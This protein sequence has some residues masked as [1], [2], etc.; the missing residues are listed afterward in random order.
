MRTDAQ[1][2]GLYL[3]STLPIRRY[4]WFIEPNGARDE[5]VQKVSNDYNLPIRG[6]E[7]QPRR[8]QKHRFAF[9]NHL[10]HALLAL[11]Y[12]HMYFEQVGEIADDGLWHLRK[13]GPRMPNTIMDIRTGDDGGL[14]AIKQKKRT[15]GTMNFTTTR[16]VFIPVDKLVAYIWEQEGG[17]WTGRSM[18]R[19]IYKNWLLK[20]R[21]LRVGAINIER[22][23]G[24]PVI[25]A[26]KGA[27]Q[28]DM[29]D[30]ALMAQQF[31]IGEEAGGAIPADAELMLARAA[32]GEEAVNYIKLQNEEMSRGWVMM[33]MNL[34]QTTSGSRALGGSFID[35]ALNWQEVVADWVVD[36]F[37]E[38]QIEDDA[39]W[40]YPLEPD[41]PAPLL[42]YVRNDDRQLAI[43][44][45]VGLIEKNVI[46]VDDELEAW[47]REEYRMPRRDHSSQ[48]RQVLPA[49][50]SPSAGG[51]ATSPDATT[52]ERGKRAARASTSPALGRSQARDDVSA[53]GNLEMRAAAAERLLELQEES[54]AATE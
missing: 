51:E 50:P 36:T 37:N 34:G 12:G 54:H 31:R 53:E 38:H 5:L 17:D 22:A 4:N 8:R 33:F 44:D 7:D 45:L 1:C 15:S 48:P 9:Q 39:D 23:G 28:K 6:R 40:N 25:R 26:P 24:V 32:G 47:I 46:Q 21:V 42:G 3:G 19:G 16:D 11:L 14:V 41:E 43:T 10:R 2:Q 35:Y 13:L 52:A 20:D 30:L 29:D 27:N 18:F 49:A